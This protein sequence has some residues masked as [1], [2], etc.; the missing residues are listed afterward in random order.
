M[1]FSCKSI[2]VVNNGNNC[3]EN[4]QF[5]EKFFFN[6]N[7]IEKNITE[8]QDVKFKN[9]LYFLS[10]NVHVSF[11]RMLNYANTY[12]IGVFEEDKKGWLKWY[13]ENKCK[14]IKIKE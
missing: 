11:D 2:N 13:D 9:I 14:N 8:V 6:I 1:F 12:P 7:Y 3:V 5:K 10:K 4:T